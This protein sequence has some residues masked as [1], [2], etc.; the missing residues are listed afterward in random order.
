MKRDPRLRALSSD[1]HHALVL[2]KRVA[3]AC[4]RG[5]VDAALREQVQASF[6]DELEPHFA[7]EE[8]HLLPALR[9]AGEAALVARTEADHAALRG[10]AAAL[11]VEAELCRF[12]ELL[13]QHARFEER[14]LFE[15]CQRV[16][17]AAVLDRL[18]SD[19]A[20]VGGVCAQPEAKGKG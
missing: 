5:Q 6:R 8:E 11:E 20:G 12:G 10:A 17:P 19:C 18:A 1:H 7:A 15:V 13:Y 4:R 16:L 14:E 2:A 9:A 3:D